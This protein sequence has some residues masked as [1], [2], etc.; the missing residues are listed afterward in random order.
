MTGRTYPEVHY[1]LFLR[2]GPRFRRFLGSKLQSSSSKPS[3]ASGGRSPPPAPVGFEEEDG[4]EV[5]IYRPG[6]WPEICM[7][8]APAG[9]RPW[10]MD[11]FFVRCYRVGRPRPDGAQVVCKFRVRH[12]AG[13]GHNSPNVSGCPPRSPQSR[14]PINP[15]CAYIFVFKWVSLDTGRNRPQPPDLQSKTVPE[16]VTLY[17]STLR[18]MHGTLHGQVRATMHVR[19]RRATKAVDKAWVT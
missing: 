17:W 11:C 14:C 13:H 1:L 12:P 5:Y 4:R 2:A 6:S 18:T 3:S 7:P 16:F 19:V 15:S 8:P 10:S 9:V